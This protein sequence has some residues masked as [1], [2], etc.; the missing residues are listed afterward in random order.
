[1]VRITACA[2]ILAAVLVSCSGTERAPKPAASAYV[3]A[4][5]CAG[6]HAAIARQFA[7]TGMARAFSD[8]TAQVEFTTAKPYYH[9]ASDRYYEMVLRGGKLVQ[10]RFQRDA[11]GAESNVYEMEAH[12]VMGSGNHSRTFLHRARDGRL[13]QLPLAWYA[14]VGGGQPFWAMNPG[15]DRPDHRGFRRAIS[16]ECMACHNGYPRFDSPPEATGAPR[17]PAELPQGIDCQRCHGP[18]RTHIEAVAGGDKNRIRESILNPARLPRDR[19]LEVCMQCHLETTSRT[20]P[21]AITRYDRRPFSYRP[22]EPLSAY[23]LHFDRANAKDDRFEIAHAAYRLRMSA[24]FRKSATLTCT[25]C[26]DPHAAR[27]R[28]AACQGCHPS[29]HN[30]DRDCASCHMP[31]RRTTD[32]VHVAMTDH[33]IQRR[34]PAG[35]LLAPLSETHDSAQTA[36][37]G[38]VE[39]Y[40]PRDA[41][42]LY[43]AAAQVVEGSNRAEGIGQ[44]EAAIAKH[45]PA[46][47]Q[48][49]FDLAEAYAASGDPAKAISPYEE[50]LRR[51][52]DYAAARR[53]LAAAHKDLGSPAQAAAILAGVN[54]D[55]G[56][57]VLRGEA[58]LLSGK[59]N[60]A[61]PVLRAAVELDPGD[62][63]ARANH[64]QALATLGRQDESMKEL[65]EA[66]RI[67]PSHPVAHNNLANALAASGDFAAAEPHY[68]AAIAVRPQYAEARFNYGSALAGAGR[69][70]EAE[71]QLKAAV[72]AQP[73]LAAAHNNLGNLSGM[74][75]RH[76]EAAGH[77]RRALA[78]DPSLASAH[79]NLAVS[80]SAAGGSPAE[81]TGHLRKAAELGDGEVRAAAQRALESL[82]RMLR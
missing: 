23:V 3:D 58:L 28:P 54:N 64:A 56:A 31:K 80:L 36:Y 24:C 42:E 45:E 16:Y 38:R 78:A 18:G 59:A 1:M 77:F 21:Y 10:R 33:F 55:A 29:A 15:F 75:G 14:P 73:K 53:G 72:A 12:Y 40:Y 43:T 67:D 25:T 30:Q 19:Q 11:S 76:A 47:P 7:A 34:K 52:P 68:R 13:L 27:A 65:R 66:L 17:F 41:G 32:V 79:L 63:D 9:R 49:Y 37:R 48:F 60:E 6:C 62:P 69:V 22:D 82:G 2:A 71:A 44:L 57:A 26:H 46:E 39:A 20:L 4:R 70:R 81:V 51:K 61:E 35:D 50:A 5:Q 8:V 74:A